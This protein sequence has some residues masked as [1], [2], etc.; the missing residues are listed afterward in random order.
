[1]ELVRGVRNPYIPKLTAGRSKHVSG[2]F[3]NLFLNKLAGR[4]TVS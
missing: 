1:M 2:P 3:D 4:L